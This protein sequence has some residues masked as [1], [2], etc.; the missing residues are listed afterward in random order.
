MNVFEH[1]FDAS[2]HL[3]QRD[4]LKT[5]LNVEPVDVYFKVLILML[6]LEL[7]DNL[8]VIKPFLVEL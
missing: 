3:M 1:T 4:S 2:T 6:N 5:T 8:G 7:G